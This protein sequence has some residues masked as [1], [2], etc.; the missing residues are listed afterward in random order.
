MNTEF[1]E[2]PLVFDCENSNL[3]GIVHK[4]S[5]VN[6]IGVLIVVGG[7]QYR[8]GSH[9]QFVKLA[10]YLS[11]NGYHVLRFDYRGM[12]DSDCNETKFENIDDDIRSAI[13]V[14]IKT[15]P[16]VQ[17]V[18]IWGLCDAAS[19]A[20]FYAYMD[21]RV[22]GLILLNPWVRTEK[23]IAK[24]YLK[25]YYIRRM[26]EITLW[27]K[28]LSR[29]FDLKQSILSLLYLI[30]NSIQSTNEEDYGNTDILPDRMK[31][32]FSRF[33]GNVLFIL[34]GHND[35]VANEFR[36]LVSDSRDWKNLLERDC[37]KVKEIPE[38]DHTFSSEKLRNKVEN[39]TKN[40]LEECFGSG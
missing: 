1:G 3:L 8:V 28:I 9:R 35:F 29:K 18:I 19:A 24:A 22:A 32:G 2:T 30:K 7:P 31:K 6:N 10:R 15:I 17:K 11:S 34:S 36:D 13:D 40:W 16:V 12:G 39:I 21:K 20:L 26:F 25:H 5:K 38:A 37:V 14:F 23:T 33:T 27:K 4:G